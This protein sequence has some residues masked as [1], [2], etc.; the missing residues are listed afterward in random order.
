MALKRLIPFITL[1]LVCSLS[2]FHTLQPKSPE[3]GFFA[4]KRINRLAVLTLPPEMMVFFKPNIDYISDHAVD[5]DMR[6]YASKQEG[7]RHFI[8]LDNYGPPFDQ[9]PRQRLDAMRYFTEIW[10]VK[11]SGDTV[12][13]TGREMPVA[14]EM[15][16]DFKRYFNSQVLPRF[17]NDDATLDTDSLSALLDRNGMTLKFKSAFFR[18]H[19]SDHGVLPWNLQRMQRDLTEAFRRRDSRRILRLCSDMGHYV[20]DAH[21]PL[22]TTSNYNG[23]KTGQHGIHGFWESRIPELFADESYDYFVGK[24]EYVSKT[25]EWFWD[26]VFA[27]NTMVD[28]VLTME[29][30]LRI[31]FPADR[32][33]CPDMRNGRSV[34][35]PCRDFSAAYSNVLNNM[36]ERRMRSAI[37][38]VSSAWYTAWVDAGQPDLSNLDVPLLTEEQRKEEEE[39]KK[40]YNNGK[41]LGR[42]EEQ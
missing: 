37:H 21:V 14:L 2:A 1:I 12:Q 32:Q 15:N 17:Y 30:A 9:I 27:S 24:P 20:G 31:T 5:P 28:S 33:I 35:A 40:T 11:N 29:R 6:R 4:H 36:I 16:T 42:P 7:P 8:D 38:A 26:I 3:W 34:M 25:T 18:E 39:L 22:H 23:Q 41:I 10:V 19:M 13:V